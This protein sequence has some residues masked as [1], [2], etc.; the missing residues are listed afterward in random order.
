MKNVKYFKAAY[1][2][3]TEE[4]AVTFSAILTQALFLL[5]LLHLRTVL[6]RGKTRT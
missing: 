6:V 4:Q 2:S 1:T 5:E 3:P